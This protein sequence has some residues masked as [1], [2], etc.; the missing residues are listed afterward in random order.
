MEADEEAGGATH[1]VADG[2]V[3]GLLQGV[4]SRD[5]LKEHVLASR[6]VFFEDRYPHL[7]PIAFICRVV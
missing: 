7:E 3:L 2:L 6:V 1:I 4:E 5:S